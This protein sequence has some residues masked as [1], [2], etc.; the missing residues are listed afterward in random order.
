MFISYLLQ[1][2]L[3]PGVK[4]IVCIKGIVKNAYYDFFSEMLII[5]KNPED[6]SM[7]FGSSETDLIQRYQGIFSF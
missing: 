3:S 7:F 1:I 4:G 6:K 2:V 5:N